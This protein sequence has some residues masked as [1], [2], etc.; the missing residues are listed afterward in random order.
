MSVVR[1]LWSV[2]L[3]VVLWAAPSVARAEGIT[4]VV[5]AD[6]TKVLV[7]DVLTVDFV[8][9]K[10][11]RRGS[12]PNPELPESISEAFDV[13]QCGGGTSRSIQNINGRTSV[14]VSRRVSCPLTARKAGTFKI[15]F[16][17]PDGKKTVAS[18]TISVEVL[19][20]EE[21]RAPLEDPTVEAP[22]DAREDVFLWVSTDKKRAYIGEQV[23]FRLDVYEARRFLD[24]SLRTSPT[25]EGFISEELPLPE[26]YATTVGD[27]PFRV[28]PGIRR[29]LFAQASGT[30]TIGA[31]ELLIDRR[32]RRFSD[33]IELDILPLPA[34]GQPPGF[35]ANNVGRFQ[36]SAKVDR[37]E[38]QPGEPLTL[39]YAIAGEGNIELL[40][41]GAWASLP[42]SVRTYDPK[43]TTERSRG[44]VV[45][46]TRR[47]E[48]LLIP[49]RSGT[50]TIP[51]HALAYFNP[52]TEAYEVA[53]SKPIEIVVGGD[54]NAIVRDD[55]DAETEEGSVVEDPLAPV[56]S[57]SSVPRELPG[58][59]WL[60]LQRWT[61]GMLSIPLIVG[62]GLGG[63][64]AW[65]RFG[66]D[67]AARSRALVRARRRERIEAAQAAVDSGEGFH[68]AVSALLQDVALEAAGPE[69]TGLPRPELFR[70]LERRKVPAEDR[71]RLESL[72]D[73][74]DA[75]RFGAGGGDA[76]ER[77]TLLD[78]ALAVV[79]TLGKGAA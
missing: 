53:K 65:R 68:T 32:K 66:P 26:L 39:T 24:V 5:E 18:N 36:I 59:R 64:W 35:S 41:P 2:V 43:V 7:G 61:L 38:V 78:D 4:A 57:M 75:A 71:R 37:D 49:E 15:A 33:P 21:E 9:S 42:S 51:A 47:Y 67:D 30:A 58:A 13:G 12:L 69:G 17:V 29:A 34:E 11:S 14:A 23:T 77:H 63:S 28:R 6:E 40:D 62:L 56:V 54:P 45:G 74:C 73:Q 31:S 46:G 76:D 27:R 44:E 55:A 48:F 79:R 8:V 1:F 22:T 60:D 70:L 10:S 72:L 19:A 20:S 52:E 50:L 25:Y 3:V 16:T